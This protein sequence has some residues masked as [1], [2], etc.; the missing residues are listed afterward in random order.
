M[1]YTFSLPLPS[2]FTAE[3]FAVSACN[4]EAW[5]WVHNWPAW[6]SLLLLGPSGSGKTHL[7]HVWAAQAGAAIIPAATLASLNLAQLPK[8]NLL[9]EDIERV[10]TEQCLLHLFNTLR[11]QKGSLLMTCGVAP[12]AWTFRLPDLT[13]RLLAAPQV[14]IHQPDDEALSGAMRKQFADRQMIVGEEV[15]QYLLPRMVRSFASVETLVDTLDRAALS[16]HRSLTVPFVKQ[17]VNG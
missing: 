6:Q 7:G 14:Q 15:I 5:Q 4:Q 2:R 13:S 8:P 1:Q 10:P 3:Q 16:E 12:S 9:V 17:Y 11:E